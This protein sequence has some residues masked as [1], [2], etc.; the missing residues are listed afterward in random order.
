MCLHISY[1]RQTVSHNVHSFATKQQIW[2]NAIS[3]CLIAWTL[4]VLL[5]MY[6]SWK[7]I[8]DFFHVRSIRLGASLAKRNQILRSTL[9]GVSSC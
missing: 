7:S 9:Q 3:D 2:G 5:P 8:I 6:W 1:Y 4:H